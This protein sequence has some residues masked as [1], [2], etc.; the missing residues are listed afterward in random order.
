MQYNHGHTPEQ[1]ET[2]RVEYL[3]KERKKGMLPLSQ[4]K[5]CDNC[6]DV[7]VH[8]FPD[9]EAVPYIKASIEFQLKK[10]TI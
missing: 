8:D 10:W 3:D 2:D 5:L 7:I 9:H 6:Q 4:E 1:I